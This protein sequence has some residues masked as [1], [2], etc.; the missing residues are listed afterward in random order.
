[1]GKNKNKNKNKRGG[2][3]GSQEKR[4]DIQ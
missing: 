4:L 1:M 3:N 2:L